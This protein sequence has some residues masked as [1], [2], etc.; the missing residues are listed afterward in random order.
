MTVTE[1][2]ILVEGQKYA[3]RYRTGLR[4]R[5]REAVA[6]YHG[7]QVDDMLTWHTDAGEEVSV[8]LERLEGATLVAGDTRTFLDELVEEPEEP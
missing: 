1:G 6:T 7:V 4:R 8:R 2:L 3:V 5:L